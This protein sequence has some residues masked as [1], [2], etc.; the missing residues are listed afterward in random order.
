MIDFPNC[1]S[2]MTAT[3]SEEHR[4]VWRTICL[5]SCARSRASGMAL[6]AAPARHP[7]TLIGVALAEIA[8]IAETPWRPRNGDQRFAHQGFAEAVVSP[9][10]GA[11]PSRAACRAGS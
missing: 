10:A 4:H 7:P 11:R 1:V 9:T 6:A 2:Y 3:P 8:E 5:G